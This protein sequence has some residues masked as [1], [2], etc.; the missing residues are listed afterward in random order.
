MIISA[1]NFRK[2]EGVWV[3]MEIKM[4]PRKREAQWWLSVKMCYFSLLGKNIKYRLSLKKIKSD[5]NS[6]I[7]SMYR[8][9]LSLFTGGMGLRNT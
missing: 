6:T 9:G 1:F 8:I 3:F 5:F 4:K 7:S 2:R